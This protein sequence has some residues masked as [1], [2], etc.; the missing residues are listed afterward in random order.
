M[1]F[2]LFLSVPRLVLFRKVLEQ[3]FLLRRH[4]FI[5]V[6]C[7]G[8]DFGYRKPQLIALIAE[9]IRHDTI[10]IGVYPLPEYE[11]VQEEQAVMKKY[12][13]KLP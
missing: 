4:L 2:L 12:V 9:E 8:N 13:Q 5:G 7:R 3:L 1:S 10:G 6:C 11:Y